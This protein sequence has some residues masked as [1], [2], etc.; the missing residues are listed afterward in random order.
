MFRASRCHWDVIYPSE[1]N[2]ALPAAAPSLSSFS[3][4]PTNVKC[5]RKVLHSGSHRTI[6]RLR[7]A[8]CRRVEEWALIYCMHEMEGSVS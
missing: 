1:R 6:R 8:C 4:H 7:A 3:S 5:D 2:E